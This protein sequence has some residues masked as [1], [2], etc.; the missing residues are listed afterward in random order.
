M[1]LFSINLSIHIFV[2]FCLF[3]ELPAYDTEI[4]LALLPCHKYI[5]GVSVLD[6]EW[7]IEKPTNWLRIKTSYDNLAPPLN[8]Q[9]K[10][11]GKHIRFSWEHSCNLATPMQYLFKIIDLALNESKI[12]EISGLSYEFQMAMG[13]KYTFS[14]S[15]PYA[16]AIP[17]IWHHTAPSLP[18]PEHFDVV[19]Q[20]INQYTF[21]WELVK[22][23][24]EP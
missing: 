8:A 19:E 24:A 5:A 3:P 6:A 2:F 14:V 4:E 18:T 23:R 1:L 11:F 17:V 13:A 12:I 20:S 21:D 22:F 10:I 15:T 16:D 9:V 7:N